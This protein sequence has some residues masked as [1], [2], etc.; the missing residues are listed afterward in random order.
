MDIPGKYISIKNHRLYYQEQGEGSPVLFIH[1]NTGSHVWFRDVMDIPG[2]R[3]IAPDMINFGR[4]DQ[5]EESDINIYA[6]YLNGFMD[7]L[8]ISN[9]LVVGH[10]LGG[11]VAMSLGLRYPDKVGKMLLIDSGPVEGL[12]TPEEHY[13][14]IELYKTNRDMIKT[15]I[16]A[17][18]PTCKDEDILNLLADEAM[19]MNKLSYAGNPRA[20][21][22][23]DYSAEASKFKGPVLFIRGALDPLITEDMGRQTARAFDGD[24]REISH[25]GHS[26]MI[27]DPALFMEI[28][29]EFDGR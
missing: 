4:S 1:G 27:E 7:E 18:V 13:S 20:L 3:T 21:A 24:Y 11:P 5:I 12:K 23:A 6:D 26:L 28:L 9:C 2:Y 17:M 25:V 19:L 8:K 14:V 29:V 15:A 10:S 16:A 22:R